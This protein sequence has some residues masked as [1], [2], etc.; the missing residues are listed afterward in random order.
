MSNRRRK[1]GLISLALVALVLRVVVV[2]VLSTDHAAPVTY[3]HGEIAKNLLEGRGF[4]VELLGGEGPTSQQ[5]PF[6]PFLLAT[7]Y[8]LFG[9]ESSAAILV[10]Q[11]LQC[12]VGV[13]LVLAVVWLAWS[14]LP[15]RPRV[16]W[17]AGIGAALYP[18]H[19]YMVTHLQVAIW[20][21]LVL[22]VLVAWVAASRGKQSWTR[23]MVA[24][25]LSGLLLLI[26]PILA[27]ALPICAWFFWVGESRR[28]NVGAFG[29][30][31]TMAG[32]AA[33]V[34]LPWTIRNCVVHGEFVF[35][36]SSFGYAFWQGNN[37]ISHGTDKI[38]KS[39]AEKLRNDH[40]GTLAG[41]DK[42]L[43][44]ARHET[45]YIDRVA[46]TEKDYETLGA[47]S[48]PERCRTLGRRAWSFI[49]EEPA[50]YAR[51]CWNRLRYFLLFDET[52][53]KASNWVYRFSTVVWLV[54][55]FIGGLVC[56]RR[57]RQLWPIFAI[58]AIVTL[59]HTL[60]IT[61]VRFR[62]PIEPLSFV[63]ATAALGR[64]V[65]RR[66]ETPTQELRIFHPGERSQD[67]SED[68]HIL[69]GP[70]Y[71]LRRAG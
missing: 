24:G 30:V 12:L 41:M 66:R 61:S 56:L 7:I 46:L 45:L 9:V 35:V 64:W 65:L 69:S 6:Y 36:K 18:T 33:L 21:A 39:T 63:W 47:M 17:V 19:L 55:M 70:H 32:V 23:A 4:S 10:V 3:E 49:T 38:P 11:L 51:L 54:M 62:I 44:E 34:I 20:A 26:E 16:G 2:F 67:N 71:P 60:V 28:F 68:A 15:D 27:L 43:W 29:R 40:D 22:T 57:W 52:N 50:S 14:L 25:I 58:F 1:I 8:S 53:P 31:A 48:E 37:P 5:A 59:F 42:A 13:G